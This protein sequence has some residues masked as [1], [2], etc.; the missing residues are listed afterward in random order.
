MKYKILLIDDEKMILS[1]MAKCLKETF[2]VYTADS[3]KKH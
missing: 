3:A 1:M 2:S